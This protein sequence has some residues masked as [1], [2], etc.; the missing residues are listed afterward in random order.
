MKSELSL[1]DLKKKKSKKNFHKKELSNKFRFFFDIEAPYETRTSR[2]YRLLSIRNTKLVHFLA[3]DLSKF[4][5][6]FL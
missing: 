1:G 2:F 6:L 4:E 5:I 3:R